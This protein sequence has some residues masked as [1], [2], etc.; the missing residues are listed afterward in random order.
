[1][2]S[3]H[4]MKAERQR[5]SASSY[6]QITNVHTVLIHIHGRENCQ[7]NYIVVVWLMPQNKKNTL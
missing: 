4:T 5:I 6:S 1:M 3:N 7:I 2:F